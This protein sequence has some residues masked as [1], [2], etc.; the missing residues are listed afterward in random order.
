M[1]ATVKDRRYQVV[2]LNGSV[3]RGQQPP[4]PAKPREALLHRQVLSNQHVCDRPATAL[5]ALNG[6]TVHA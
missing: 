6:R 5:P 4:V 3:H 1:N 2:S